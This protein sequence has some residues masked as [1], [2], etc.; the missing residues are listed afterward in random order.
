MPQST[1][2]HTKHLHE[3]DKELN[4]G[5]YNIVIC[6]IDSKA[7]TSHRIMSQFSFIP[8]E[9]NLIRNNIRVNRMM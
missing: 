9:N 6:L 5:A 8:I 4:N 7:T 1:P 3:L 2:H